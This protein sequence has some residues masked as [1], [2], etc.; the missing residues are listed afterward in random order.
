[1]RCWDASSTCGACTWNRGSGPPMVIKL[2]HRPGLPPARRMTRASKLGT[3]KLSVCIAQP[4]QRILDV[5]T[6]VQLRKSRHR[7]FDKSPAVAMS[8]PSDVV[9]E[10]RLRER[11]PHDVHV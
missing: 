5:A 11:G 7:W 1:M 9:D 8:V 3:D 4:G 10:R 2:F 6:P